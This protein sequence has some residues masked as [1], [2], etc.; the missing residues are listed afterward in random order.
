[1]DSAT[2]PRTECVQR[3]L[4]ENRAEIMAYFI[5]RK[6]KADLKKS[7][8]ES[9]QQP[10]NYRSEHGTPSGYSNPLFDKLYGAD[11]NPFT[12]TERDIKK[13]KKYF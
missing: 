4:K 2:R 5:K 10:L 11:K 9:I 12:G 8:W 13:R 3:N 7:E 1:M 6:T